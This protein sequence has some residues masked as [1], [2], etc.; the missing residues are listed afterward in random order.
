M[1]MYVNFFGTEKV[2]GLFC[3]LHCL[4]ALA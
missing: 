2:V 3:L 1:H 4:V